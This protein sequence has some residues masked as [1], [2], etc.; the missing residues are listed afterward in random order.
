MIRVLYHGNCYD[1]FTAA[2]AAWRKLGDGAEYLPVGYGQPFPMFPLLDTAAVYILD[3]SYPR[4][5]LEE[6]HAKLELVPGAILRVLDHHKTAESDL[7]GLPFCTF[8][9]KKSGASL[10]WKFFHPGEP[11]PPVVAYAEDRDL[12]RFKLPESR[13]IS[14][15]M[16]SWPFTFQAWDEIHERLSDDDSFSAV[17]S[18][19]A[20]ILRF[21][22]QMVEM[23]CGQAVMRDVGGY[24]VPVAN[25]TVFFSEVGEALCIKRPDAPFAAYYLDRADGKRQWGLRSR[26]GFDVSAVAKG[27]G[28][29]GHAAAAGFT[30]VVAS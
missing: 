10:A 26:N 5:M 3:F 11:T 17:G 18:E 23:M 14:A 21:Q 19:G 8:D 25:A 30:E 15:W 29:G 27:L 4:D 28:G 9:M 24:S 13:E 2:W 6:L 7:S 22:S 12:W 20:A 16:R 1:G